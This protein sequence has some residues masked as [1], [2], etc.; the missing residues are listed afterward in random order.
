MMID[1]L[2]DECG[3]GTA[4]FPDVRR[5]SMLTGGAGPERTLRDRARVPQHRWERTRAAAPQCAGP[6]RPSQGRRSQ[7]GPKSQ[8][9]GSRP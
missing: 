3:E 1:V 4:L 5:L 8:P 7:E 6:G 2:V 9:K